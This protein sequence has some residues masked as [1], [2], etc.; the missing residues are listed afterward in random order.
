MGTRCHQLAM[1]IVYESPLQ[2]ISDSP[3]KYNENPECIDLFK[4][5][6]GNLWAAWRPDLHLPNNLETQGFGNGGVVVELVLGDS[7]RPD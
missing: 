3:T 7:F 4:R 2:M 1:Y 5:I 6:D